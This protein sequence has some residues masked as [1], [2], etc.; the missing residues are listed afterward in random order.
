MLRRRRRR[1]VTSDDEDEDGSAD[2]AAEFQDP[3][4]SPQLSPTVASTVVISDDEFVDVADE[5]SPPSSSPPAEE[6][7][8]CPVLN[9]LSVVGVRPRR[10]WLDA[11]LSGLVASHDGF[12]GLD[13]GEKARLCFKQFLLSDFNFSSS[14]GLPSGVHSMHGVELAGPFVLQVHFHVAFVFCLLFLQHVG[15]NLVPCLQHLCRKNLLMDGIWIV[16][17]ILF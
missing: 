1:L 8:G 10:E 7:A 15:F 14:G 11:C 9:F 16:K 17:Q 4:E 2:V 13:V 5:L 6:P 3:S 12:A